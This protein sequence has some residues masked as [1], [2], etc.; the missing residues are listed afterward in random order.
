MT[1][2]ARTGIGRCWLSRSLWCRCLH[3]TRCSDRVPR[4]SAKNAKQAQR[5]STIHPPGVLLIGTL[6]VRHTLVSAP[7]PL[8]TVRWRERRWRPIKHFARAIS[9]C[10]IT[11]PE[12]ASVANGV[13][14]LVI[15]AA[16]SAVPRRCIGKACRRRSD[17]RGKCRTS[18]PYDLQGV[19][20]MRPSSAMPRRHAAC[21]WRPAAIVAD[22]R[23]S[24]WRTP[25]LPR[26]LRRHRQDQ[27][28][29]PACHLRYSRLGRNR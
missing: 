12:T 1:V 11:S 26:R 7:I 27:P 16:T 6:Q 4:M 8:K 24:F 10:S 5:L 3:R 14:P 9:R 23:R 13:L 18:Y 22:A 25:R 29:T 17:T 21:A 15:S 2:D 28:T 20:V 19:P